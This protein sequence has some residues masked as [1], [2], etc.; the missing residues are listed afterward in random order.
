[1]IINRQTKLKCCIYKIYFFAY[2]N[3]SLICKSVPIYQLILD[4]YSIYYN[5]LNRRLGGSDLIFLGDLGWPE[6][7]TSSW[8]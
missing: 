6:A 3:N 5:K 8:S 2:L 4:T 1:M 7:R